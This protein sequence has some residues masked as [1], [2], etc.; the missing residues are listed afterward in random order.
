MRRRPSSSSRPSPP[1]APPA[2]HRTCFKVRLGDLQ[3][4]LERT[5]W[6]WRARCSLRLPFGCPQPP[7]RRVACPARTSTHQKPKAD[8]DAKTHHHKWGGRVIAYPMQIPVR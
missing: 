2:P 4:Y 7:A 3:L 5:V 1:H 8:T 6:L